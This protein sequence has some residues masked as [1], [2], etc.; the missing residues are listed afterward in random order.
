MVLTG[1]VLFGN[2]AGCS[3]SERLFVM[4][5]FVVCRNCFALL[6]DLVLCSTQTALVQRWYFHETLADSYIKAPAAQARCNWE[7]WPILIC[8][9]W[10]CD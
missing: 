1:F 6:L 7:P 9:D 4:I 3:V 10:G 2:A 5:K 8:W